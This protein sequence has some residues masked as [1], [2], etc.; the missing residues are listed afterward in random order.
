LVGDGLLATAHHVVDGT[1][2]GTTNQ[3]FFDGVAATDVFWEYRGKWVV[4][5]P[6]APQPYDVT[7]PLY[8]FAE[9]DGTGDFSAMAHEGNA[10]EA[11]GLP[12][13]MFQLSLHG[14][15][16]VIGTTEDPLT[17]WNNAQR[18]ALRRAWKAVPVSGDDFPVQHGSDFAFLEVRY[19]DQT[20]KEYLQIGP[21]GE[22]FGENLGFG[23]FVIATPG[24]LFNQVELAR[25]EY[26]PGFPRTIE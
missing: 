18:V 6:Q 16:D 25:D 13:R 1:F 5:D 15:D 14:S 23:G 8:S 9:Q 4:D 7:L 21:E 19:D 10:E 2:S 22:S 11:L 20:Y 17:D 12:E 3:V 24:V 26:F